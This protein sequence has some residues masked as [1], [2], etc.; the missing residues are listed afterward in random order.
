MRS[1]FASRDSQDGKPVLKA[2]FVPEF[3]KLAGRCIQQLRRDLDANEV[4]ALAA[5]KAASP[6]LQVGRDTMSFCTCL[7]RL[8]M[9][10]ETEADQGMS[11][12]PESLMDRAL[13][14]LISL[15]R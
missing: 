12:E 7:I 1:V 8:Q 2:Q 10:I 13:M 15:H 3:S 4:R 14:G 11:D 5:N 6:V 9:L